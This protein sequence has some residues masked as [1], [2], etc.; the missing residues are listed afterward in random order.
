MLIFIA[1]GS[2]DPEW[3]QT[4][5]SAVASARGEGG[6]DAVVLAYLD[7][8]P[9]TLADAVQA[10]VARGA[11]RIRIIPLFLA[12]QGHVLRDLAPNVEQLRAAHPEV[13]ME[14]RPTMGE[15]PLFRQM[16]AQLVQAEDT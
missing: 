6:D 9:P 15:H 1:H 12:P 4:V 14:L 5:E 2:R 10:A 11:R 3:R 8:A 16:L 7:C 13:D